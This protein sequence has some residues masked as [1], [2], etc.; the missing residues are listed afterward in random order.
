MGPSCQQLSRHAPRPDWL[1]G[2]ALPSHPCLKGTVPTAPHACPSA[3]PHHI[4][5]TSPSAG[6]V[7]A[8][9]PS[10]AL[11]AAALL[12]PAVTHGASSPCAGH[13]ARPELST[14]TLL[15]FCHLTAQPRFA[16]CR[17]ALPSPLVSLTKLHRLPAM[18][19]RLACCAVAPER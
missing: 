6:R 15:P 9:P 19:R 17:A 1:A 2:A 12:P 13:R 3:P 11:S 18:P 4:I 8:P 14:A 7:T 10:T 5:C 16:L